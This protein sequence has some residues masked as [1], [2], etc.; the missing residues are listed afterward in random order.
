MDQRGPGRVSPLLIPRMLADSAPA[1]IAIEFGITG[2]NMAV[3]SACASGNNAIGEAWT[4]IRRGVVDA[5]LCG[6]TEAAILPIALAGF[7][8]MGALSSRNDDPIHACRPFDAQRDGFV[9]GEGAAVLLLERVESAIKRGASIYAELV[10]YGASADAS[11]VVAPREDGKGAIMAMQTALSSANLSPESIDYINAHGTGTLLNDVC[12]TR[13]VKALFGQYAYRVPISST[14]AVTGHLLGAAG[15]LGTVICC[16]A[17]E[18]GV[19]P[20][21]INYSDPDPDCDLDYVPNRFRE[22]S[23][24]TVMN[25]AF[26]FGGHNAVLILRE[27]E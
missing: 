11:S 18:E 26:G 5:A 22:A 13:A 1:Q 20:P 27:W 3:L 23:I 12:E 14:K 10:G 16:K 25:N 8:A 9:I 24:R 2:P 7:D 17:I 15:A 4:M 19:I 21:T 6:G